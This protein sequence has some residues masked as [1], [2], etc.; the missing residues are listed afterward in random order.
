MD[1]EEII[2]L[3]ARQL[4]ESGDFEIIE[5]VFSINYIAHA[6]EKDYKG[7]DFIKKFTKQIRSAIPD[8]KV[9]SIEFLTMT[10]NTITWQR[11]FSG[12]HKKNMKGIPPSDKKIKWRDMVV[13]RFEGDRISEEWILSELMGELLLKSPGKK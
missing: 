12:T 8:I 13:S 2:R 6:G 9:K 3:A 11:T 10:G 1:K 7:Q 5:K 4:F